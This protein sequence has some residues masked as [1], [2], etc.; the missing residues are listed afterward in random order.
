M[1]RHGS[2]RDRRPMSRSRRSTP[3]NNPLHLVELVGVGLAAG[4]L[5]L[6]IVA[7]LA[8][9][10]TAAGNADL[11]SARW[12]TAAGAT[13][14]ASPVYHNG[15]LYVATADGVTGLDA[16]TGEIIINY[17]TA[18]PVVTTPAVIDGFDPQP[19]PPG[20]LIVGSK[21]GTLSTF[22]LTEARLLWRASLGAE[23]TSPLVIRGIDQ[24]DDK[25]LVGAG[26]TL[27]AFTGDGTRLWSARLEG[28][29]I[30]TAGA[31]L[32]DQ[33]DELVAVPAGTTLYELDAATG[34]IVWSVTP[35]RSRLGA[36]SIGDPNV[37]GDPHILVGDADGHLFSV[38]RHTG[39][40]LA[41]FTAAGPV[42]GP[43]AIGDPNSAGPWL[44]VGDGAG[45]IYAFDQT[46]EFPVWR[47]SLG[48]PIDGPPVLANNV[49]YAAPNPISGDPQL[50]ALDAA[51]G[52]TRCTARLT[53]GSAAAPTVANGMVVIAIASGDVVAYDG[54]D[55]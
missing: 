21:D 33:T 23:P 43:A 5:A 16:S 14:G 37:I 3:T 2:R 17:R 20:K 27:S 26:D 31:V 46:D 34:A 35:G 8:T 50:V 53:G 24:T 32:V 30:S 48:G 1:C 10:R 55:S 13:G 45:D 47:A 28:G 29:D 22:D 49:L 52:Q 15:V 25:V 41:T 44:F 18:S 36:A 6:I 19:D 42:I 9:P 7:M 4:I 38:D 40:T 54:P 12:V 39:T 11:L 51:T